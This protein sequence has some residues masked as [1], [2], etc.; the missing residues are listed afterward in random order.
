LQATQVG[1]AAITDF[2]LQ[3]LRGKNVV[4]LYSGCG[5]YSFPIAQTGANV[6][7]FEGSYEMVLAFNN[8][9]RQN[10]LDD[11]MSAQTRDLF[12][13]PVRADELKNFDTIIINP[14]RNGALPQTQQIAKAGVANVIMV[15]CNPATFERDA[16]CLL[17]AGYIID[18][19]VPIDQFL[20]SN[21][22]ELVASFKK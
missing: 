12:K 3:N 8:A 2:I 15:S 11:K 9:I 21:H 5:T 22:L 4:D 1:Q 20:W 13:N 17:Q 19:I 18:K 16:K 14:P 6:R 7:A 10:G